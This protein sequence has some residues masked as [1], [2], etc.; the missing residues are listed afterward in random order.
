M[1]IAYFED[2]MGENIGRKTLMHQFA[3]THAPAF[4]NGINL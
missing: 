4:S 1:V 2:T 3:F